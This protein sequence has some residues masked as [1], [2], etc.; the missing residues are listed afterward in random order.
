VNRPTRSPARDPEWLAILVFVGAPLLV[1]ATWLV[2]WAFGVT[3]IDR[4]P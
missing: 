4:I 2:E 1:I 3:I